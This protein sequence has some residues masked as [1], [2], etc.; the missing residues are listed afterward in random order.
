MLGEHPVALT[1]DGPISIEME[2]VLKHMPGN[3]GVVS[4]KVLEINENHEIFAALKAIAANGDSEKL[5]RYA[6]ILYQQACLIE[7]LPIEDPVEYAKAVCA[8][9]K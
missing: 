9:M 8:L 1:S 4:E 6:D 5:N 7:G 2:K 3:D